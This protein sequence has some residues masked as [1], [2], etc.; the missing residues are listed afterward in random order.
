[1]NVIDLMN[2][3]VSVRDFKDEPLP[4]ET[5][6][7]LLTAAH[8]GSSSNFVQ[9]TSIIEITD[10]QV[11]NEIAGISQSAVYVKK[12][13]AFYIF[14][15]DLYRQATL[16][17]AHHQSL[18]PIK[19]MESLLVGVVDTTIAAENM[20]V[21]AESLDLGICYI[22]GIRNNLKRI[23]ELLHL[24]KYTLPLFGLT[25]GE[26]ITRNGVKPRLPLKN[27]V[28]ENQ[29]DAKSFTDF[30]QYDQ[31]MENYYLNRPSHPK[32]MDWS[33]SQLK[34]FADVKRPEVTDFIQEQGFTLK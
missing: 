29:Y 20:A 5:K 26:P 12:S 18:A 10:E 6:Q 8:A 31:V 32:K 27:I 3:H 28:S 15:A 7:K 24:P 9:A 1:M 33:T 23:K 21:A 17:E 14:V 16:L 2:H 11:R 30:H 4:K 13:G 34:F 19:N 25:I 22:G